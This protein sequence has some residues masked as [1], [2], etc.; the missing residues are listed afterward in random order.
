MSSMSALFRLV[1]FAA[2]VLAS[3]AHVPL[4]AQTPQFDTWFEAEDF[5]AVEREI[6]R[7][8]GADADDPA[9][10]I[11]IARLGVSHPDDSRLAAGIE[12]MER[13]LQRNEAHARCH[14]WLGRSYGRKAL[15]AGMVTGIRYAGRIR[16]HFERAVALAPESIE[17]RFDLNQFYILA[18][19]LAGGGK[20]RARENNAAFDKLRPAEATLLH[21]QLDI[22]EERLPDADR[23]LLGFAGSDDPGVRAV[24]QDQFASLG[25]LY[26]SR[27]PPRLDDAQRVFAAAAERFPRNEL[28]RRGLGRVAQEQGRFDEAARHFEQALEIKAQPGA[29]YRLAQVAEKLGDTARAITHYEKTLRFPRDVPAA[30]LRDSSER[31]RVLQKL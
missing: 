3:L 2:L 12:A 10:L 24:W 21:A 15:E 23:R 17:A 18:P 29:H 5:V 27:K 22:A 26:F 20:A 4:L 1:R 16:T 25:F 7:L 13:C 28:F 11:A 9:A 14:L 19:S 30:V 8:R 6:A 31:L